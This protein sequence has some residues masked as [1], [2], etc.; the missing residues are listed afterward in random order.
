MLNQHIL[1]YFGKVKFPLGIIFKH[2][3]ELYQY[4]ESCRRLIG[5][6]ILMRSVR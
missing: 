3:D 6:A 5:D 1:F 4:D 2:R